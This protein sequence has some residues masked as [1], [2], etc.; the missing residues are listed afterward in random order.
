M[1]CT[2]HWLIE[3]PNGPTSWGRCKF[4][5]AEKEFPNG[6]NWYGTL[7]VGERVRPLVPSI[8]ARLERSE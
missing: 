5:F 1:T 8:K 6:D 3:I 7:V 2:H 4:C